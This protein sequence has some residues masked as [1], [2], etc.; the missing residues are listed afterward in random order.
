MID[1]DA[2][3]EAVGRDTALV[4]VMWANN[5]VGTLQP[6]PAVVERARRV[7]A[8]AHSDAVQA[9]G[10]V[11]VDFAASGLDLMTVTAHKLGGPVGVGALVAR[12][13]I[14]LE[15]VQHGG[16]QE[17][18]VRSG[19]LD[20]AAVCGFRGGPG[21]GRL[22]PGRRAGTPRRASLRPGGRGAGGR[23]GRAWCTAPRPPPSGFPGS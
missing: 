17:R 5:E 3:D 22:D 11:P 13:E 16:G 2:L 1:P 14:G 21:G 12:R 20:A 10:H 6:V 9:V 23:T 8:W 4:S 7:G 19:T 15:P 18:D